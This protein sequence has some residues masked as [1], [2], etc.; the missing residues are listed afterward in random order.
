MKYLKEKYLF[1][2]P[3]SVSV[4]DPS[5]EIADNPP[6]SVACDFVMQSIQPVSA[7]RHHLNLRH[8]CFFILQIK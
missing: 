1:Y 7:Q 4:S 5:G 8:K 2:L 3:I 6:L